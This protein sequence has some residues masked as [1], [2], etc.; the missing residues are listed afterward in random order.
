VPEYLEKENK[1]ISSITRWLYACY[2]HF[3]KN[4]KLLC[5]GY[6]Y[7]KFGLKNLQKRDE[8]ICHLFLPAGC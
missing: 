1:Q 6:P 4:E 7:P 5:C 8:R 3:L 2:F